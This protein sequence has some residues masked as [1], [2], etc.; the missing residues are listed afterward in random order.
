LPL[1]F[2][3]AAI[4]EG[5][6]TLSADSHDIFIGIELVIQSESKTISSNV[7]RYDGRSLVDRLAETVLNRILAEL[8]PTRNI[9]VL[10]QDEITEYPV[11]HS[12]LLVSWG[13]P[14][15]NRTFP[16]YK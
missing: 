3:L 5:T 9:T 11:F 1:S 15:T 8:N 4:S 10:V 2:P 13:E 7:I 14:V 6:E 12:G 16:Q